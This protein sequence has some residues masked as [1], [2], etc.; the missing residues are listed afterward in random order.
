MALTVRGRDQ[1]WLS[2]HRGLTEDPPNSNWDHRQDG[3]AAAVR[4][5][6]FTFPVPWC[7]C[8]AYNALDAA[9]VQGVSIRQASVALI[10]DDARHGKAPFRDWVD[11]SEWRRVLRGDLVVLFGRGVHVETVRGFHRTRS[12]VVF[13]VTDGGNTS[14]GPGGSQ[15]NGGGAFR[16]VRPLADVWGFARVDYPGG[17]VR[18]ALDRV[19]MRADVLTDRSDV[20]SDSAVSPSSDR[21]LVQALSESH[22]LRAAIVD[23][24]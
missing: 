9:G 24:L 1:R 5:C 13:A 22:P 18:R 10:E 14:S 8:W 12:G 21:A 4:R 20:P 7:G 19:A 3:I 6:G 2:K 15:S 16:R 17:R 23:A 11:R